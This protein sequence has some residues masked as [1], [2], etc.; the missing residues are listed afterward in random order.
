MGVRYRYFGCE[1]NSTGRGTR[2]EDLTSM[3]GRG[4]TSC[5]VHLDARV[6]ATPGPCPTRVHAHPH[7]WC[8]IRARPVVCG[9][10]PLRFDTGRDGRR[11]ILKS[12]EERITLSEKLDTIEVTQSSTHHGAV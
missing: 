12:N 7:S 3:S 5:P 9:Q 6:L 8:D 4:D 1:A 2:A 10:S 11:G